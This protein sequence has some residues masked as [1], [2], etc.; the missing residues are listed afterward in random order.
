MIVSDNGTQFVSSEY[1]K[2]CEMFTIEHE[3]IVPYCS[4]SNGQVEYFVDTFKRVLRKANKEAT[5]EVTLQQFLR[6]YR[7]TLNP[8]TP[9]GSSP[10]ELMF[11][12]KVK[13]V[14]DK[15]LPGK[16]RKCTRK[17]NPKFFRRGRIKLENS[18][19]KKEKSQS[20]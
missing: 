8:N 18:T 3:T 12:R 16:E 15:L 20:I 1:R 4:R 13:S 10:T 7:V 9:A 14:F 5:D 17:D 19:W 11:V 6:V 2:F